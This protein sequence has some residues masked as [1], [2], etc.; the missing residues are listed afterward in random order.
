MKVLLYTQ[1]LLLAITV[2]FMGCNR[3][4]TSNTNNRNGYVK[5]VD[6]IYESNNENDR[7]VYQTFYQKITTPNNGFIQIKSNLSDSSF[8]FSVSKKRGDDPV[9]F[10]I[11]NFDTFLE[12][13]E[14]TINSNQTDYTVPLDSLKTTFMRKSLSFKKGVFII[15][16]YNTNK[17]VLFDLSKNDIKILK[18][19]YETFLEES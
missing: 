12:Q 8:Y 5:I 17:N 4:G 3:S 13:A 6:T 10:K 9:V 11:N 1:I 18:Q 14:F 7:F 19:A 16:I 2:F 15:H